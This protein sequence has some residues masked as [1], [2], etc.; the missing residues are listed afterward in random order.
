M[1]L[2]GELRRYLLSVK[3]KYL[4][5]LLETLE[6][7]KRRGQKKDKLLKSRISR[8]MVLA[9]KVTLPCYPHQDGAGS[10]QQSHQPRNSGEG[11]LRRCGCTMA[12]ESWLGSFAQGSIAL[13]TRA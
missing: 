3:P 10:H 13:C 4:P 9:L 6:T 8:V 12:D 7:A 2:S 5:M 11:L 1:A